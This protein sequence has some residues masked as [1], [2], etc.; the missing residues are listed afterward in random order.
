MPLF[1]FRERLRA[2]TDDGQIFREKQRRW[3]LCAI[4]AGK[5]RFLTQASLT[6]CS[7]RC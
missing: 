4:K 3:D 7:P 1:L 6:A 5:I 2:S